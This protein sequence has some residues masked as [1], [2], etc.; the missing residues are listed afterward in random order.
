MTNT[1][2]G[3]RIK[4]FESNTVID[5]V[6][7]HFEQWLERLAYK[8][9]Q[10]IAENSEENITIKQ[11]WDSG[12]REIHK[13]AMM[14]ALSKYEINIE[15]WSSSFDSIEN[16]RDDA[17]AKG[18]IALQYAQAWVPIKMDEVFK[19]TFNSFEWV[20]AEKYINNQTQ[21]PWM[22]AIPWMWWQLTM[23]EPTPTWAAAITETVAKWGITE[24]L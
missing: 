19:D 12:F 13:S 8:L 15:A 9:L 6:R 7:K 20:N 1:A 23:P 3:M 17:I 10:E 18:N 14:D 4:F 21:I 16:R 5:E 22:W 24:G 2:T 11:M